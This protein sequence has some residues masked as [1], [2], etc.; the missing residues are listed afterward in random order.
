MNHADRL[1]AL[2]GRLDRPLLV[3][4]LTNIRYLTGF[5]GSSAFL[6]IDPGAGSTFVT[7]GRYGEAAETLIAGLPGVALRVYTSG[8]WDALA[9]V[10]DGAAEVAVEAHDATWDFVR[11]LRERTGVDPVATTGIV[12]EGR[13]GKDA[14]EIAALRAAAAAGDAAF[15]ALREL[16][17]TASTEA[18]LGRELI[19]AMRRHGAEAAEWEPIVAAGAA[20]S[21][22]HYRAGPAPLG[23]GLLLLDYGCI[24]E[25][26]HSD[27]S[28]TVWLSGAPEGRLADVYDAVAAA[29]QAGIEAVAPGVRCGAVDEAA[30]SVLDDRGYGE[31]F[32]HS[33]GHGV[34]LDIH[35]QPWVRR[36]NDDPLREG[37][38]ITVEPGVYLPGLGGVRIE[39]MVLVADTGAV[40]LT[41]SSREF[42]LT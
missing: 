32:L 11:T 38:V 24:V 37:D 12:E 22:P 6:F 30:R 2:G 39:D 31:Q 27:M 41:T 23:A 33:T 14:E 13:R 10:M 9:D 7:D 3:T 34:G 36:G 15:A 4:A 5:T 28:R 42:E 21:L 40:V 19:G 35:E 18:E 29:Q 17:S 8:Q 1:D 25:G 16:L 26:Y 20:A